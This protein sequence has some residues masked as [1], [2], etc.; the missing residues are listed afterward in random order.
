[1]ALPACW[2]IAEA[3]EALRA[4]GAQLVADSGGGRVMIPE[5]TLRQQAA[6]DY[7]RHA[8]A[9]CGVTPADFAGAVQ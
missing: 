2:A 3:D 1:V 7:A 5:E 4:L 8:A 9:L 6:A